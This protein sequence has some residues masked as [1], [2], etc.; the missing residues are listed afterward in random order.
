MFLVDTNIW[1]ESLL[2]QE[3]VLE[4]NDFLTRI[5]SESLFITDFAFHSIGLALYRLNS[6]ELLASFTNDVFVNGRVKRVNLTPEDIPAIIEVIQRFGLDF[7]DAYQYAAAEKYG[8]TI[9]SFDSD[10]DRTQL[11]RRLPADLV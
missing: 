7:D 10:F 11:G 3:R 5:P 9:V 8:L 2:E 1:V 4:V 6:L